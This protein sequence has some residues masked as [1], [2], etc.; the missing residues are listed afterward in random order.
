ML[1][2]WG[3]ADFWIVDIT[4]NARNMCRM[5]NLTLRID[6][7]VLDRARRVAMEQGKTVNS[8][9]REYLREYAN[10]QDKRADAR[11]RIVELCRQSNAR[12]GPDGINWRREDLYDRR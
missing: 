8:L 7:D 3:M 11:R 4:H 9:I 10:T 12:I 2:C 1:Q 5:K 6:E